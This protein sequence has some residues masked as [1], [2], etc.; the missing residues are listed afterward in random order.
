MRKTNSLSPLVKILAVIGPISGTL[1]E[2]GAW[3]GGQVVGAVVN[4]S[5]STHSKS[6]A[7]T[8]S[9]LFSMHSK[10]SAFS[11]TR[12]ENLASETTVGVANFGQR[13]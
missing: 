4:T 12:V 3:V 5:M 2:I 1:G 8:I 9:S 7:N 13:S 10:K 6:S 11:L